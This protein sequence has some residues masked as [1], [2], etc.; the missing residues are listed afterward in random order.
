MEDSS[1]ITNSHLEH[2]HPLELGSTKAHLF[3]PCAQQSDAGL[4]TCV[5]E[6]PTKRITTTI[7]VNVGKLEDYVGEV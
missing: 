4:Y 7:L 5:A 1:M 6:T 2:V 3:I